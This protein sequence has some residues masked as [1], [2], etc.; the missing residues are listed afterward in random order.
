MKRSKK[1]VIILAANILVLLSVGIWFIYSVRHLQRYDY[2]IDDWKSEH[3]VYRNNG[4]SV[5]DEILNSGNPAEFLWGPYKPLKKGSYTVNIDYFTE[6]D[7]SCIATSSGNAAELFDS[8]EGILSKHLDSVSYRFETKDDVPEFQLVIRYSGK[9]DFTVN[10]ISVSPDSTQ[11]KRIAVEVIAFVFLIDCVILFLEQSEDRK[12][13]ILSL[14]GITALVSLPLW[15]HGIYNGYD[16]GVHYLRIEAITQALRSGQFPARISTFTMYGLGYPFSIYYNDLFLYFPAGLRLLGFSVTGAYKIYVFAV[17]TGT[18]LISYYSFK[19][20]FKSKNIGLILSLLY[21]SASYRLLNVNIRAAVGE[22]SAQAL[23]PLLSF[24]LYRIYCE[25]TDSFRKGFRNAFLLAAA[26]SGIIGTHIL[27][28]LIVCFVML[29]FCLSLA[30]R[31]FQRRILLTMSGTVMLTLLM[32]LYFLVPF[33][34]Y[35]INVPAQINNT[36]TQNMKLIQGEGIYP[37]QFFAFF[38][39]ITGGESIS[40]GSRMQM[41]PGLVLMFFFVYGIF[42]R[43]YHKRRESDYL[44]MFSAFLLI[45]SSNV[46]PW[47]WLTIHFPPWRLLTQIQYPCRFFV[48]AILFLTLLSGFILQDEKL[49]FIKPA[50]VVTAVLMTIWFTS[51]LFNADQYINIHDISGVRRNWISNGEYLLYGSDKE[52]IDTGLRGEGI[53]EIHILSKTSDAIVMYVNSGSY[54][55]THLVDAPIYAYKGYHVVDDD[56]KEYEYFPGNQNRINFKLPDGFDGN[57]TIVFRAPIYWRIALWV[58]I[59]TALGLACCFLRHGDRVTI[60]KGENYE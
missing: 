20:I 19:K 38:Q 49:P 28:T 12:K 17:N 15:I 40:V 13:T 45:L 42:F 54:G 14:A 34:D 3:A 29:L 48:M 56:G 22:Y 47:N 52:N 18:V 2:T 35:Y 24:A 10:S 30:K 46:F 8:S 23:L 37:A 27:T 33:M 4:Y 16:L 36:I 32:N 43:F 1:W 58:S 53:E 55:E 7:Q 9:G 44:L 31:T 59:L 5:D 25:E 60:S 50:A 21:T 41:T 6:E 39:S 57:I 11:V 51:N 26:M